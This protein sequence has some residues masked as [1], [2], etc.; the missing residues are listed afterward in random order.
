MPFLLGLAVWWPRLPF[1]QGRAASPAWCLQ[2]VPEQGGPP[3]V[4]R[5]SVPAGA[6]GACCPSACPLLCV[7]C[8]LFLCWAAGVG[9]HGG[10]TP[11]SGA[12]WPDLVAWSL[13]SRSFV[14]SS[15]TEQPKPSSSLVLDVGRKSCGHRHSRTS[16]LLP[17]ALPPPPV[18]SS[19]QTWLSQ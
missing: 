4:P 14:M 12:S 1:F 10:V 15:V 11:G 5:T 9:M 7:R 3:G 8:L 2:T 6:A 13:Q 18:L 17:V 19:P 16:D